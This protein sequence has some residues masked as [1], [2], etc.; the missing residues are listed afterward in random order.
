M[1]WVAKDPGAVSRGRVSGQKAL[2]EL[3]QSGVR[4]SVAMSDART[5]DLKLPLN[6]RRDREDA[7]SRQ[8]GERSGASDLK[9]HVR[10]QWNESLGVFTSSPVLSALPE[11]GLG[12]INRRAPGGT[13]TPGQPSPPPPRSPHPA[14]A[15][16]GLGLHGTADT[17][18][19]RSRTS[20]SCVASRPGSKD[21]L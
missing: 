21:R 12:A 1:G 2:A 9:G 18:A 8:L 3:A 13:P 6:P 15:P 11:G 5:V 19:A 7:D 17:T 14:R 10:P 16:C 20:L 4:A